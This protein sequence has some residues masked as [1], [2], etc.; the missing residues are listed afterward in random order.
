[1][2][3][4]PPRGDS[5]AVHASS[6]K[7]RAAMATE[8]GWDQE[9]WRQMASELGWSA[10]TI[11]EAYGGA[12]AGAEALGTIFE[13]L[14]RHV[15]CAPL[16]S[17]VC[18]GVGAILECGDDAQRAEL[19]PPIAERGR[20]ATLAITERTGAWDARGRDGGRGARRRWLVAPGG[21]ALRPRRSYRRHPVRVSAPIRIFGRS[22]NPPLRRALDDPRPGAPPFHHDAHDPQARREHLA[23]RPRPRGRPPRAR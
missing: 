22:G 10:L 7:V 12:A 8:R 23:R 20:T 5:L 15:A 1:M 2:P 17:T 3:C 16:F 14:G 13:E 9:V 6:A 18:L 4:A 19:L 21:E 11:P